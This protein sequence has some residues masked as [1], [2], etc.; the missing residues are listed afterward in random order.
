MYCLSVHCSS[1][2]SVILLFLQN[3]LKQQVNKH[4]CC[5]N[6]TDFVAKQSCKH[7]LS[8][9]DSKFGGLPIKRRLFLAYWV[10]LIYSNRVARIIQIKIIDPLAATSLRF[11]CVCPNTV[12]IETYLALT[13]LTFWIFLGVVLWP[14]R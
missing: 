11:F 12:G 3:S 7:L 1:S 8:R 5:V 9:H 10:I 6:H 2:M 13:S 4:A 14:S